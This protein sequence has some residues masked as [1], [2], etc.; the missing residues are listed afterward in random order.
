MSAPS[1]SIPATAVWSSL[2]VAARAEALR[3][4]TQ[5]TADA[6]RDGVAAILADVRARGDA[7]LSDYARRFDRIDI[8]PEAMEVSVE[9]F[10][11]A[12]AA[13]DPAL[14]TAIRESVARID[15]F[16][17]DGGL[18]E[19][20]VRTAPGVDCRRIVRAIARVGL[21]IPAGSAPLPSTM[22]MLGVPARLA[23]C[24]E[25]VVCTPPRADGRADPTVL[26]AARASV[27]EAAS[28]LR[29]FKT[30]GA[31]AVAAMAFGTERV[32]A[33]DKLFGPG[34]AWV[35]EAKRQVAAAEGGP[36]IDMPA[37]PSEVLVI[38]D[39]GANPAY[40][41][42]DLLSQAEHGP[43]SQV[44]LLSDAPSL[45]AN[46]RGCLDEQLARLPRAD[47]ARTAL[48]RSRAIETASIDEAIAISNRYAPEHVILAL[49]DADAWLPKIEAAGS[50]FLGDYAN[51]GVGDYCSGPNHVLPTG[52]AARAWSGVSLSSFQ[53]AISVQRL[54]LEGLR[55]IGPA[56]MRIAEAEGL[57]AHANAVAIRLADLAEAAA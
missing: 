30:G 41:A 4:P 12:D 16:H 56:A 52:G 53:L 26:F 47:I 46:V 6:V 42:A 8:A 2:D 7:A 5:Y 11:A 50:V 51:E 3:R 55:A 14:K 23:G 24:G 22:T 35:T 20:A 48:S 33:C 49:R 17:R 57:A 10:D 39:A 9:E 45:I 38:A 28:R 44:L 1:S 18:R 34:N 54:D 29:V 13:L 37:G 31:Q 25:I 36:A 27:G 32:P 40:V 21:Y 43:D 19:Y 15:A